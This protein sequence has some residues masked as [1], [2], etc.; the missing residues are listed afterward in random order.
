MSK[1]DDLITHKAIT[2]FK[3][4][5]ADKDEVFKQQIKDLMLE[6]IGENYN[7]GNYVYI[8]QNL[9]KDSL[10]QKVAEL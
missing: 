6:L 4:I 7:P 1:L 3:H 5:D 10:R 2:D 9:E 8:G